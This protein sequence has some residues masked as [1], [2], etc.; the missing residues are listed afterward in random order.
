MAEVQLMPDNPAMKKARTGSDLPSGP[1][2]GQP[3][4]QGV[5]KTKPCAKFFSVHGCPYWSGC[6]FSHTAPPGTNP[7]TLSQ[8][9]GVTHGIQPSFQSGQYN[10]FGAPNNGGG[11][12]P[13]D[14][15]VKRKTRLCNKF[16][17]PA[18]CPFGDRCSF[19]HGDSELQAGKSGGMKRSFDNM[20]AGM[21]MGG[22]GMGPG[23]MGMGGPGGMGMGGPGGMGMGGPGGMGMGGMGGGSMYNMTGG[24]ITH[25]TASAT[26]SIRAE[27]VGVVI[28]KGGCNVRQINQ[29]SGARVKILDAD[30]KNTAIR[31]IEMHGSVEQIQT[32]QLLVQAFVAQFQQQSGVAAG[33][34]VGVKGNNQ[35]V[36]LKTRLCD[37]F[38][39]GSCTYGDR[40][41]FAHGDSD[42]RSGAG[43]ANASGPTEQSQ[44]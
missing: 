36:N 25:A 9:L 18:G 34:M 7:A 15:T 42:L 14:P 41:H 35:P 3:V 44:Q 26:M 16:S 38:T 10:P 23:G 33:P 32:A 43:E 5:R 31:T 1:K 8:E 30:E 12:A 37:N 4:A 2:A 13:T 28:G 27:A 20:Q 24:A 22:M 19:A 29:V 40:C 6:N 11:P 17:T 21:G 39:K